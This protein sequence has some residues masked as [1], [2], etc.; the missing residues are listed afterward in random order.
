VQRR[1]VG[2]VGRTTD[3]PRFTSMVA[4]S[5]PLAQTVRQFSV[6]TDQQMLYLTPQASNVQA[7]DPNKIGWGD[8][9]GV[10]SIP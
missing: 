1:A 10:D 5:N 8:R 3:L 6:D 4:D 2:Y 7:I 9:E